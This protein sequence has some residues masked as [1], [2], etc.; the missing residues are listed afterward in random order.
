[1][2][3]WG[4][5]S[6]WRCLHFDLFMAAFYLLPATFACTA[7]ACCTAFALPAA[8]RLYLVAPI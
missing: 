7:F 4:V 2:F 6:A 3:W 1:M 5:F 8:F